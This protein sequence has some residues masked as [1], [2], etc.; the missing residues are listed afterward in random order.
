M[1]C[2]ECSLWDFGGLAVILKWMQFVGPRW[3]GYDIEVDEICGTSV[4]L[5]RYLSG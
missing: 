1:G 3:T 5:L 2:S 4:D